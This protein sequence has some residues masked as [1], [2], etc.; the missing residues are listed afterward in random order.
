MSEISSIVSVAISVSAALTTLA[1]SD[2]MNI[3]G[4]SAKLPQ[5][6]RLRFYTGITSVGLDYATTDPE[7]LGALKAFSQVPAP[8][9][10]AISRRFNAATAG[11]LLGGAATQVLATYAAIG[12]TGSM[13]ITVDGA[14]KQVTG[15]DFTAAASMNAIAAIVQTRLQVVAAGATCTWN[16]VAGRFELHSGTTGGASSL[17]Y[18]SAG[19]TGVT[20]HA[21]LALDAASNGK[22]TAGAAA[23]TVATS[24]A[25]IA[26]F[27]GAWT[28]FSLT[29]EVVQADILA[30]AAW[31]EA[32]NKRQYATSV[33]INE[34]D[35]TSTSST[36]YLLKAAGYKR[37]A[38]E[39]SLD[40]YAGVSYGVKDL[41]IDFT[42]PNSTQTMKFKQE[43][44][45][46][47][48]PLTE[49]QRLALVGNNVN[50]DT[51]WG[52][53]AMV[54]EG[55]QC[56][57]TY[58]D[59]VTNLDWLARQIRNNAF[60]VLYGAPKVPQTDPGVA[61]V[62]Q[63]VEKAC[64]QGV[65]NGLAAP[66]VWGGAAFGSIKTGDVLPKGFYAYAAPVASQSSTQRSTRI[67]PPI[68]V[69]VIGAGAL[70]GLSINVV[71]QP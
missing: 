37:T 51:T 11:E 25:N 30:A 27:N 70:H 33:A 62:L 34:L 58:S 7:Y 45:V 38:L 49:T 40:P 36:G 69:A 57:G 12:A 24:L 28:G 4:P 41:T 15:M 63:A 43:P 56:D 22:I 42:Q 53:N 68:T 32:A 64:A 19:S 9:K 44:G 60:G 29:S 14:V 48:T 23:E 39:Y 31:A 16:N 59:Q 8:A 52:G 71:F 47:V 1:G 20:A 65:I 6:E 21:V 18:A 10:I 67:A 35:A 66:G 61:G 2:T 26:L 54:A 55:V 13:A 5:G 46:A 50:Y 17:T 3:V